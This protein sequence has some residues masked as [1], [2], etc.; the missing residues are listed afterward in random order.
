VPLSPEKLESPFTASYAVSLICEKIRSLPY[1]VNAREPAI[2]NTP[3]MTYYA[4]VR[5]VE[6]K[7]FTDVRLVYAN[8]DAGVALVVKHGYCTDVSRLF[9]DERN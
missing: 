5:R 8:S 2:H 9:Q 3:A 7:L 6:K 4:R 1:V